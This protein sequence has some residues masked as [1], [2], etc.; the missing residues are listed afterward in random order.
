METEARLVFV[1]ELFADPAQVA[2][3][4]PL[5]REPLTKA[6]LFNYTSN[7]RGGDTSANPRESFIQEMR[8]VPAESSSLL[9]HFQRY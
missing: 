7:F 8:Q 6:R 5:S 3:P 9:I 4:L 1:P 2:P